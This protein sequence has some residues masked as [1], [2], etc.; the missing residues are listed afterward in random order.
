MS[1]KIQKG[2]LLSRQVK[3]NKQGL[4]LTYWLR[5]DSGPIKLTI[6]NQLAIFFVEQ[7]CAGNASIILNQAAILHQYKPLH[8][9]NFQQQ[10]VGGFYF[11]T[12]AAF[13]KARDLLKQNLIKCFEDDIRPEDRFLME[14]FITGSMEFSGIEQQA[15]GYI[16]CRQGQ[17]RRST[18]YT[19]KLTMLSVDIECSYEG[20]LFSIGCY[21]KDNN[22]QEIKKVFMIGQAEANSESFITWVSDEYDLLIRFITWLNK[23]DPDAI[24]GWNVVNFDFRLLQRRCDLN[25]IKFAIGRDGSAPSWRQNKMSNEQHFILI[26]GRVVLD[27][28][29]LLKSA[30]YNFSSFSLENVS[31]QLLGIGK[32]IDDVD[33]RVTEI[34]KKF[35]YHK[36]ELA[37]YNLEDC[38]LV[39]LIFE[40]THLL[41][42]TLLRSSLTGLELDRIGG[43]VAAFTNLYLPKLHRS[44]YIAPNMGDGQSDLISPGGYVMDSIPGLYKNVLVLD[45]K[46]LYPSIIRSFNIDPLGLIEGLIETND[47]LKTSDN[48]TE[49][50]ESPPKLKPIPGF[51]GA[52]FS[53][54]KH[55][56]P[57]IIKQLWLERDKAKSQK[58]APLSQAIKIIM[59]SFY[60]I[61]GSTGCRFYDPRLSGSITKRSHQLLNLTKHWIE[62]LNYSVIYGDTD[63]IFVSIGE[64]KTDIESI[65]IGK[66]MMA[67]I[68]DKMDKELRQNYNIDSTLE[69][70][71]E[72]HFHHFLMPTVR[73]QEIGTKKRYAGLVG[74]GKNEKLVFKGLESVRTDWTELAKEFQQQLYLKVFKDEPVD[75]YV[76]IMIAKTKAGLFDDKLIYRK[77]LR[78]KLVEYQKNIPPHVKAAKHADD[79]NKKL[80]KP[81]QY[82]NKGWIEYVITV[83]GPQVI[84]YKSAV[85]DYDL[86]VERQLGA[87]ADGILP[88]IGKRFAQ[89]NDDQIQLL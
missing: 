37:K 60:G 57:D 77:R 50:E 63:S 8:L 61:L 72:T 62:A 26:P 31:Q 70:E 69:I 56:L 78:R 1:Q 54:D 36:Q 3:D 23:A 88:F 15:V 75:D 44:G 4:Q 29:D 87:V 20:D 82:Q 83:N 46:S 79:M 22:H 33:N 19:P 38:R 10:L 66:D 14:R 25:N 9:K 12:L 89:L 86:Y 21:G 7:Q 30:T 28:I 49:V 35:L 41:E 45:F 27:G 59:N 39:W 67:L 51:D 52:Y 64:D 80:G 47:K 11:K 84:K 6:D 53:R 40:H 81:L 17:A 73:G 71:F 85:L 42:F 65:K 34:T 16:D 2:F 68:N 76:K 24:I 18:Q 48:D 55:F 43:S 13:Y 58:N 5:N 32:K 74:R